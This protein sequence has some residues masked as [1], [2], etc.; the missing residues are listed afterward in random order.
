MLNNGQKNQIFLAS[1]DSKIKHQ[2]LDS[3]AKHYGI[4]R[5]SALLE[6]TDEEAENILEY[7]TYEVRAAT[8]LVLK[9]HNASQMRKRMANL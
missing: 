9:F 8:S 3:I 7:L 6:V 1:V 5:E 4:T 2:I